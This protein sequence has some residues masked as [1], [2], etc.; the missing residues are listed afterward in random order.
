MLACRLKPW[1]LTQRSPLEGYALVGVE[2]NIQSEILFLNAPKG[3]KTITIPI[4]LHST[5]TAIDPGVLHL[6]G[7]KISDGYKSEILSYSIDD[8][9][10]YPLPKMDITRTH[11]ASAQIGDTVYMLGGV[12][13]G[14]SNTTLASVVS[15][16][17]ATSFS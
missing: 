11:S 8:S 3:L 16:D 13:P 1:W 14:T 2:S 17:N 6:F 4:P 10:W 9:K 7:G 12:D 5:K 15:Y